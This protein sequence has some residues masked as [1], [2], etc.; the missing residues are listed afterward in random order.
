MARPRSVSSQEI[1][2]EAYELLKEQGPQHLTFEKLSS[3]VG[4]V[5]AALVRRFKNKHQLLL[6][7]DRYALEYTNA[8]VEEA[9]AATRS[10]IDAII[11]QFTAELSFATTVERFANAQ[12]FLLIDFREKVLYENYRV[13]FDHRQAQVAQL[14]DKAVAEGMLV[15]QTDTAQLALHLIMLLHGSGHVWAMKQEGSIEEYITQ[16]VWLALQPYQKGGAK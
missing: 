10:P 16:H 15:K 5:P 14:L 13:S 1:I 8:K 4:L 12:E 11:A 7:I 9:M 6:E 2:A 3:R